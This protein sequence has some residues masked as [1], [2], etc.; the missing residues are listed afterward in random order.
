MYIYIHIEK[1]TNYIPI[2]CIYIYIYVELGRQ[3]GGSG[4]S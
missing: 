4:L 2:I 1:P 3:D